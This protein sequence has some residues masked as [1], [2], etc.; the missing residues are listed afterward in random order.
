M[1]QSIARNQEEQGFYLQYDRCIKQHHSSPKIFICVDDSCKNKSLL[2]HYCINDSFHNYTNIN[3]QNCVPENQ[4]MNHKGHKVIPIEEYISTFHSIYYNQKVKQPTA[5]ND[6]FNLTQTTEF[7]QQQQQPARGNNSPS[8]FQSSDWKDSFQQKYINYLKCIRNQ[9][10][11]IYQFVEEQIQQAEK[12]TNHCFNNLQ[13]Y[14]K[15]LQECYNQFEKKN[16]AVSSEV[17]Q[18]FVNNSFHFL[19]DNQSRLKDQ[20]NGGGFVELQEYSQ[21]DQTFQVMTQKDIQMKIIQQFN[22]I[23]KISDYFFTLSNEIRKKFRNGLISAPFYESPIIQKNQNQSNQLSAEDILMKFSNNQFFASK[24]I[25]STQ[26][27]S[28][29]G[30]QNIAPS[31]SSFS[32][33]ANSQNSPENLF[34]ARTAQYKISDIHSKSIWRVLHLYKAVCASCSSDGTIKIWDLKTQKI[35]KIF[36][37]FNDAVNDLVY[38]PKQKLLISVSGDNKIRVFSLINYK[39]IRIIEGHLNAIYTCHYDQYNNLLLTAG[40]EEEVYGWNILTG[41]KVFKTKSIQRSIYSLQSVSCKDSFLCGDEG[42]SLSVFSYSRPQV[43]RSQTIHSKT[44]YSI[45]VLKLQGGNNS[46][47]IQFV[48]SSADGFIKISSFET[49]EILNQIKLNSFI[50]DISIH[51]NRIFAQVGKTSNLAIIG[52]VQ[53]RGNIEITTKMITLSN[54]NKVRCLQIIKDQNIILYESTQNDINYDI[55]IEQF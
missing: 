36:N 34:S 46:R 13:S 2:C 24:H 10:M 23:K 16:E 47:D 9:I 3:Q 43:C 48:T 28:Q 39:C 29:I 14:E 11:D 27:V 41:Q 33:F 20:A 12:I 22:H 32:N 45:K 51:M 40:R 8:S 4:K 30:Q 19:I 26:Q 53:Q 31:S 7:S 6:F 37:S 50:Y 35:I 38:I 17:V 49:L 25:E 21:G 54:P 18:Q 1:K 15:K 52:L 55:N 42:G 44:I 5:L